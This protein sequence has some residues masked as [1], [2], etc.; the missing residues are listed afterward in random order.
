LYEE[1]SPIYRVKGSEPPFLFIQGDA[2][3]TT[4]LANTSAMCNKIN[5]LGG[6]AELIVLPGVK[7]G[8]G[9]GVTSSAQQLSLLYVSEFLKKHE[10][11]DRK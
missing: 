1:A 3:E 11:S 5:Q 9:Y 6:R 10:L 7:H 2:D 8:F 4:T